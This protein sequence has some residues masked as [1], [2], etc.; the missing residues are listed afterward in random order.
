MK[1]DIWPILLDTFA[2]LPVERCS[3][4]PQ[5]EDH[6]TKETDTIPFEKNL[7]L[8]CFPFLYIITMYIKFFHMV[9]ALLFSILQPLTIEEP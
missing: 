5:S 3:A 4:W 6:T 9:A 1:E 2:K 8:I 7:S